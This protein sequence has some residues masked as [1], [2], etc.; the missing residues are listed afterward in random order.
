MT[1][2]LAQSYIGYSK[3]ICYLCEKYLKRLVHQATTL[4]FRF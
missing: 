2:I 3:K 1:Q 4:F